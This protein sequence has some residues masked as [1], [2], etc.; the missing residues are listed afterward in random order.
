[1]HSAATTEQSHALV[2]VSVKRAD[3]ELLTAC[4]VIV[5]IGSSGQ[6]LRLSSIV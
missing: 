5:S 6:A 1:M 2:N 3:D 4:A